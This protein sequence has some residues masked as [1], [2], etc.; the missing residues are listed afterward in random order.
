MR[1]RLCMVQFEGTKTNLWMS[2]IYSPCNTIQSNGSCI[3]NFSLS[4][5]IWLIFRIL[6]G[7]MTSCTTGLCHQKKSRRAAE[8]YVTET[9]V[10]SSRWRA[11]LECFLEEK[12]FGKQPGCKLCCSTWGGETGCTFKLGGTETHKHMQAQYVPR[13]MLLG[14]NRGRRL[15]SLNGKEAKF[16]SLWTLQK[17]RRFSSSSS[18]YK[19]GGVLKYLDPDQDILY[20]PTSI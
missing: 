17:T 5:F 11:R 18:A 1:V 20:V 9:A 13:R 7:C 16:N 6:G 3:R 8:L 19:A 2:N 14:F 10:F 4:H 12:V 15:S